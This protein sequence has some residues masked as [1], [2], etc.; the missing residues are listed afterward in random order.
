MFM[1]LRPLFIT[2]L[3]IVAKER[4][5]MFCWKY[6][7]PLVITFSHHSSRIQIPR[8]KNPLENIQQLIYECFQVGSYSSIQ[9]D[10]V[11]VSFGLSNPQY[12]RP[13]WPHQ[14]RTTSFFA[15][16]PTI[17]HSMIFSSVGC[18]RGSISHHH[19]PCDAN[20]LSGMSGKQY[21]TCVISTFNIFG[22]QLRWNPISLHFWTIPNNFKACLLSRSLC[23]CKFLRLEWKF[24]H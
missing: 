13:S 2:N 3:A 16:L 20:S 8:W 12:T 22:H 1:S 15:L 18:R 19:W 11:M 24:L 17:K 21:F 23:E 4:Y 9:L 7:Q 5:L 6:C 10:K 14:I